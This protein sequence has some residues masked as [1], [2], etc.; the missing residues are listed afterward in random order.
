MSGELDVRALMRRTTAK[1]LMGWERYFALEPIDRGLREAHYAALIASTIA[2]V[3]RGKDQKAY[4][5]KDFLLKFEEE[6]PKRP[7]WEMQLMVARAICASYSESD[8]EL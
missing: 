3:Q 7:A 6:K 5:L 4:P 1:R 2:N 8:K